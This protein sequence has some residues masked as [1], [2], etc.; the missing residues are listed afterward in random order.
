MPRDIKGVSTK[1]LIVLHLI[2]YFRW[3]K[4]HGDESSSEE[5]S[6]GNK[7]GSDDSD[8]SDSDEDVRNLF[9]IYFRNL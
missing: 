6:E 7:S 1:D 4:E 8:D 2:S 9:Y 5:G 3:R